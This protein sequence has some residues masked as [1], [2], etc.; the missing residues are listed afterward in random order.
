MDA[1]MTS[2]LLA[3]ILALP[4]AL[5]SSHADTVNARCDIYPRGSDQALAML[6]CTFSQRQGHVAI[7]RA[8]GVRHELSPQGSAGMYLDQDGK[9]AYRQLGLGS[10]GQIYRLATESVFVYWDTA[11]LPGHDAARP[12]RQ[13]LEVLPAAAAPKVP[14][15][16]TLA[17]L[18]ITFRLT[19]ANK[20]SLTSS[21]RLKPGD[22]C[23]AGVA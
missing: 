8:D 13:P 4:C 16:Q 2:K 1:P 12:A 22:S 20:G 5:A 10:R 17:L 11:G 7:D 6:A 21:P 14:F 19:S 3:A 18:G 23:C 9:A 15:D